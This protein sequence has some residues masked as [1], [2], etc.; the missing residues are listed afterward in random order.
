MISFCV[1]LFLKSRV[2]LTIMQESFT[3][4]FVLVNTVGLKAHLYI[5]FNSSSMSNIFLPVFL[6]SSGATGT[7][8]TLSLMIV[9][10]PSTTNQY[11]PSLLR[12]MSSGVLFLRKHMPSKTPSLWCSYVLSNCMKVKTMSYKLTKKCV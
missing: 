10:L 3:S 11:L 9:S 1:G 2:S 5:F 12:E 6:C 4:R 7:G 8:W